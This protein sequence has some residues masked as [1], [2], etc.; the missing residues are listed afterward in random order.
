MTLK[1]L[2]F[3]GIYY[4]PLQIESIFSNH[5]TTKSQHRLTYLY[6]AEILVVKA[7]LGGAHNENAS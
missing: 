5:T 2:I 3:Y 7:Q 6:Q 4:V 1:L